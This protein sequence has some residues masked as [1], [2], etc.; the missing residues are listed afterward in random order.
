MSTEMTN[1]GM[2]NENGVASAP[3]AGGNQLPWGVRLIFGIFWL[4]LGVAALHMP[5]AVTLSTALF[6]G[7]ILIIGGIVQS[8]HALWTWK[9]SGALQFVSGILF[10]LFGLMLNN[11]LFV[12]V[13]TITTLM[14]IF[15]LAQGILFIVMA[16]VDRENMGLSIFSGILFL[17]FGF[18][19]MANLLGS[20]VLLIGLL[21]GIHMVFHGFG[22]I[23]TA[24]FADQAP[25]TGQ[26]VLGG[27][28]IA[29]ILV[30]FM[31]RLFGWN[32]PTPREIME[33]RIEDKAEVVEDLI[34]AGKD[35]AEDRL[36]ALEDA[37]D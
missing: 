35:A 4:V 34:D 27:L 22:M 11:N 16:F 28:L 3:A 31:G 26:K 5:V 8:I 15:F 29:F 36:K 20:S 14:G 17:L 10:L 19:I 12:G 1:N 6:L 30:F 23:A 32:E 37:L 2:N 9:D 24:T 13:V 33:D 7:W 21:L 18:L 25:G